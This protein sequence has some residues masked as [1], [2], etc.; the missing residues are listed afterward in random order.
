MKKLYKN[1]LL[2]LIPIFLAVIFLPINQRLKFKGLKNDCLNHGS[3]MHD[4]LFENEQAIDLAFIGSSHTISGVNDELIDGQLKD[5]TITNLGYCRLGRNL[6][7]VL[8]K[9]LLVEKNPQAIILEVREDEDRYS[10]PIFPYLGESKEVLW[11]ALLFNRDM[12]DD[13][14]T[15]LSYKVELTQEYL[16]QTNIDQTINLNAYGFGTDD[17][18]TEIEIMN[19]AKLRRSQPKP[20]QPKIVR[21]FYQKFPR[22]YLH[23]IAKLCQEQN[24]ELSFLYLPSYGTYLE[25]PLEYDHYL[26]YGEVLIPPKEIYTN[27]NHWYDTNHLNP[28]GAKVLS[29][30]LVE[31]IKKMN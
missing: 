20:K 10:H 22:T 12:V 19:E 6:S 25:K 3:W 5:R 28:A 15:H 9:E 27:P 18:T 8:L 23:K 26:K 13:I 31:Q 16:Y 17:D 2:F 4:R 21:D 29:L 24:I 30:W 7:Y 14:T 1:S 11:P